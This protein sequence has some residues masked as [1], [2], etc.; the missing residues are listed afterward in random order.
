MV[1][2]CLEDLACEGEIACNDVSGESGWADKAK[3]YGVLFG[4]VGGEGGGGWVL[5]SLVVVEEE[6]DLC[7]FA[8]G[9]FL[10]ALLEVEI[11]D[12]G[13]VAHAAEGDDWAVDFLGMVD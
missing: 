2:C 5:N 3:D 6:G 8:A 12:A 11:D 4:V 7:G 10:E 9:D 13:C 1:R